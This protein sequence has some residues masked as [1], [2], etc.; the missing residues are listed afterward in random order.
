MDQSGGGSGRRRITVSKN[1][2]AESSV[3]T[4]VSFKKI[5]CVISLPDHKNFKLLDLHVRIS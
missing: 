4:Q 5:I 2:I 1:G 3:E